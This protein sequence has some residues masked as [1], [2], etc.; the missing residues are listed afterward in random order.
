MDTPDKSGHVDNSGLVLLAM[1]L[2]TAFAAAALLLA[3]VGLYGVL[4]YGVTQR[5]RE[6]GIR[7]ALGAPAT[8]ILRQ[9]LGE[10]FLLT[11]IGLGLGPQITG[12]LSDMLREVAGNDSLRYSLMTVGLVTAPWSAFHYFRAGHFIEDD[13]ANVDDQL[14]NLVSVTPGAAGKPQTHVTVGE[15]VGVP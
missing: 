3:G 12:I 6:I 9:V 7:V 2:L 11:I 4:R 10:G 14:I 1:T 15:H 13:I 5:S 8:G